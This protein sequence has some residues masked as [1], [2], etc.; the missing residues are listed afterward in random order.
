MEKKNSKVE[1]A[2]NSFGD[3]YEK[4]SKVTKD[5][6]R[7][8]YDR[9]CKEYDEACNN[10]GMPYEEFDKIEDY[11]MRLYVMMEEMRMM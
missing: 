1:D 10:E 6:I 9:S 8:E 3:F 5:E 7:A 2:L 4:F 11:N